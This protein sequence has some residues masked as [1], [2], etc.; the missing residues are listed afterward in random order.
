[1]VLTDW[2]RKTLVDW[3]IGYTLNLVYPRKDKY[4]HI[5]SIIPA[6]VK[7]LGDA[8][9]IEE[10]VVFGPSL[11]RIGRGVFIGNNTYFSHCAGIGNYSSISTNVKIGLVAHPLDYVS[12]SPLL[13]AKRR[14]WTE[15]DPYDEK[16][17]GQTEIGND[18]LTSANAMVLA[19]V[20]IGDG[21]VIGAGAFVNADVPPYSIVGGMPAKVIRY[22][23]EKELIEELLNSKWWTMPPEKLKAALPF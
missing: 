20:K 10:N 14:G 11:S 21:A 15:K 13:Y 4:K 22:R 17:H 19:G 2:I 9:V 18:V 5:R 7:E 12:T 23:F 16:Q 6:S 8:V 1:M 3:K